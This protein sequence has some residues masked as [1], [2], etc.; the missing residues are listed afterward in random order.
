MKFLYVCA[1][2][3][4]VFAAT[5]ADTVAVPNFEAQFKMLADNLEMFT[6]KFEELSGYK[7]EFDKEKFLTF[8]KTTTAKLT[9]EFKTLSEKMQKDSK[10]VPEELKKKYEE[11]VKQI[12]ETVKGLSSPEVQ[13]KAKKLQETMTSSMKKIGES[14]ADLSKSFGL[15]VPPQIQKGFTEIFEEMTKTSKAVAEKSQKIFEGIQEEL[16]K[17]KAA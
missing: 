13:D 14:V 12:N 17:K 15:S 5:K 9:E 1:V 3:V 8:L 11:L 7:T 4:A 2:F 6:K 16:K 10:A